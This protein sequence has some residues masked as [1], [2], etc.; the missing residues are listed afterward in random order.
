MILNELLTNCYKH[1]FEEK[2]DGC[3]DVSFENINN[4][5]KMVV[6]DNGVGL[7][8]DYNTKQSLGV[9]VITALTEQ[10]NGNSLFTNDDGTYFELTFNNQ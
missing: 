8:V 10:L 6:R 3:I 2:A 5:C 4:D 7:P 1:A 9:S